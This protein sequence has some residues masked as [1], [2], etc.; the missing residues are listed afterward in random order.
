[1]IARVDG[2]GNGDGGPDASPTTPVDPI[3]GET[4]CACNVGASSSPGAGNLALLLVAVG[5]T[6]LVIV[7]R[8]R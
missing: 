3:G 6:L 1:V 5:M 7:R 4:G 8:R 2:G